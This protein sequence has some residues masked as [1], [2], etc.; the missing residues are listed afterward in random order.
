VNP[1]GRNLKKIKSL[2]WVCYEI[3]YFIK[4]YKGN[5]KQNL[6]MPDHNARRKYDLHSHFCNTALFQK[7]VLNMGIELYS[8]SHSFTVCV[9]VCICVCFAHL[10]QFVCIQHTLR[11]TALLMTR[12]VNI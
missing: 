11:N 3:V 8:P 9:C 12:L 6:V 4:E 5:L 1:V 7:S 2:W 10:K